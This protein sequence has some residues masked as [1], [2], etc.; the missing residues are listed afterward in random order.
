MHLKPLEQTELFRLLLYR[1]F[2]VIDAVALADKLMI[3]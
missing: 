3:F 2:S 1:P